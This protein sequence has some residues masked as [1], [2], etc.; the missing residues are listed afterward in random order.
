M[1]GTVTMAINTIRYRSIK[2]IDVAWTSDANGDADG[3]TLDISGRVLRVVT[4]PG[5][6]TPTNNYDVTIEDE[7]GVDILDGQGANRSDTTAQQVAAVLTKGGGVVA[8]AV[9]GTI[10]PKV[11]NAG[12]SK[13]GTMSIYYEHVG[14]DR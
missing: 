7:D 12:D 14:A 1:A 3:A 5:A 13:T 8:T 9:E 6:A 11:A 10:E 4:V 2:K